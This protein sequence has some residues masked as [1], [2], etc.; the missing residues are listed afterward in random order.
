MSSLRDLLDKADRETFTQEL[1]Q[2][3]QFD[4][5][6]QSLFFVRLCNEQYCEVYGEGCFCCWCVREDMTDLTFELWGAGGGGAGSCC[7]AWGVPGGAGA[8]AFKY[9]SNHDG[10]LTGSNY[11]M[12]SAPPS[13]C[14][15][16]RTCGWRG[17]RSY[18]TGNGISN[19]CAEGGIPGCSLCFFFGCFPVNSGCGILWH[20]NLDTACACYFGADW[21][22]EGKGGGLEASCSN[23]GNWCH[24]KAIYP[25]P[26]MSGQKTGTYEAIGAHCNV[27]PSCDVCRV[28]GAW[29]GQAH[30]GGNNFKPVG[31]GGTTARACGGACCYGYPGGPGMI[32]VS[33]RSR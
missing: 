8:Y 5:L 4:S 3:I 26:P 24:Y 31:V 13:C 33:W 7:C 22:V 12:C 28:G 32:K 21:G 2:P 23:T 29:V 11:I 9:L 15:P 20:P 30:G 25:I 18:M 10:S 6:Y 1:A 17:C 14:S 19:F 16:S 27:V